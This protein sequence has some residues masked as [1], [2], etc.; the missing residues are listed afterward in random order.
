[1]V[2][3][4]RIAS[5]IRSE[6]LVQSI[7]PSGNE[8]KPVLWIST[9]ES[10]KRV[11]GMGLTGRPNIGNTCVYCLYPGISCVESNKVDCYV[12]DALLHLR[13]GLVASGANQGIPGL[14]LLALSP[15]LLE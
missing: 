8:F 13:W 3:V 11:D 4:T 2:S 15:D 7:N 6:E 14:E 12:N 5:C 9:E 10:C 1:M